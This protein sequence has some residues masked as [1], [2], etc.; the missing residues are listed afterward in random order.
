MH[1]T[2]NYRK[3]YQSY[4]SFTLIEVL[5]SAAILTVGLVSIIGTFSAGMVFARKSKKQAMA[6][7]IMQEAM[8]EA[9]G[10]GYE[11]V[12]IGIS[13]RTK[14]SDDVENPFYEFETQVESAF[15]DGDLNTAS[16]DTGLKKI[17]AKVF[18]Q[19]QWGEETEEAVT[20]ISRY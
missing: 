14:F 6:A 9:I 11:G 18:W 3:N 10:K 7:G 20:L 4:N 5:V 1:K 17:I 8:E 16:A 19:S 15:V 12:G 2:N 13:D